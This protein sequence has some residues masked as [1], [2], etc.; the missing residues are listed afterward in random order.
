M[1]LHKPERGS[2]VDADN[3]VD[4]TARVRYAETDRMGVAYYA[5]H[6]VWFEVGRTEW[7]RRKGF[8]YKEM[9]EEEGCY[10]IVAEAR[11]TYKAPVRYDDLITIRTRVKEASSRIITF[12]YEIFLQPENAKDSEH[13]LLATGETVHVITDRDGR[14]RALPERY[15]TLFSYAAT[16]TKER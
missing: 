15:R 7:F 3:D 2:L 16:Q 10:I 1:D 11:C 5:N 9:E 4:I 6:F 14:P 12:S 13:R 8:V